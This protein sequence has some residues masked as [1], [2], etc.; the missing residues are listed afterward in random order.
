MRPPGY[1]P[2]ELPTATLRDVIYYLWLQ[3]DCNKKK[4]KKK[5]GN[6]LLKAR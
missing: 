3:R 6:I 5:K 1:E 2:G 4:K